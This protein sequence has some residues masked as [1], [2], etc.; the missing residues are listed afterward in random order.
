MQVRDDQWWRTLSRGYVT[1]W[2]AMHPQKSDVVFFADTL[3]EV[4][5][6]APLINKFR[7]TP[8]K[9]AFVAVTGAPHCSCEDAASILGWPPAACHE[10]RFKMFNLE[11]GTDSRETNMAPSFVHEVFATMKGL[12]QIHGP[13]LVITTN[14]I[15]P[16]VR[17]ALT[18][19]VARFDGVILVELPPSAVPFALWIPDVRSA[20]LQCKQP[21]ALVS[22][23]VC[24]DF[25]SLG[26][27]FTALIHNASLCVFLFWV[28]ILL[29]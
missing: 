27:K 24:F 17:E 19:A 9:K 1:Q 8:G 28:S 14:T 23:I 25:C 20:A 22:F 21:A 6:L 4:R 10:R 26:F 15:A 13:S 16:S 2:A 7:T 3:D 5:A 18:L 12:L 29:H 11:I